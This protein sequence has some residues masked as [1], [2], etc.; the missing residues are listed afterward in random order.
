MNTE[1][2]TISDQM[3][4]KTMFAGIFA[5]Q[6]NG[7]Y[8]FVDPSVFYYHGS[9][10]LNWYE[11]KEIA[12]YNLPTKDELLFI[13]STKEQFNANCQESEK[14]LHE[15]YWTSSENFNNGLVVNFKDGEVYSA[16]KEYS[17]FVRGIRKLKQ[18]DFPL[19]TKILLEIR[20]SNYGKISEF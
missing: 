6:F 4:G 17:T 9:D 5:G 13:F 8:Y 18:S 3:I 11:C 20:N 14:W 7:E 19:N 10:Q 16:N 15:D 1:Q 12:P 2:P